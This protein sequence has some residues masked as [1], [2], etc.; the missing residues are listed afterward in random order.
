MPR[1]KLSTPPAMLV[2]LLSLILLQHQHQVTDAWSLR[3]SMP[4][5][6]YKPPPRSEGICTIEIEGYYYD[7]A[8]LD[9]LKYSVGACHLTPGQSFG[10]QEDC[11]QTCIR[12]E[13]KYGH[14]YYNK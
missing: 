12:G 8:A 7:S 5:Y 4:D 11:V 6:C 1:S 9:C 14:S 2:V 10:S 3:S 13:R